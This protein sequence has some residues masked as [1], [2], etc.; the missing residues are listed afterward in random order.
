M[1]LIQRIPGR[2][3]LLLGVTIFGAANAVTRQLTELGAENLID[4]RNPISFCNVLFVGNIWAL[5]IF[6][7]LY[8]QQINQETIKKLSGKDWLSLTSVAILAGALAPALF[9]SALERTMVNNVILV[10][11]IEP[12]LVLALSIFL[13]HERVNRWVI[14]GAI[15]SFI[16]VG[17]TVF[18]PDPNRE[19]MSMASFQIGT[20][21]LMVAV[22]A[23]SAAVATIISKVSLRNI[24][25]GFFNIYRTFLST[26]V[27]FIIVTLLFGI[28]HFMDIFSPL[29]WQW[30]LLYSLVIVVGGQFCWFSGLQKS[31]ASEISLANSFAP[32]AGVLASYLILG[33]VPT[34]PQYIG[35]SVIILGI[36][37]NQIGVSKVPSQP[38]ELPPL[39]RSTEDIDRTVGFKGV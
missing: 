11:R 17:L 5:V 27:F 36:I 7:L 12:P 32:I 16:G 31:S 35:G 20:G 38:S 23:V 14:I 9:F 33:E 18:I 2:A 25:L 21:E 1:N 10:S 39:D 37:F 34:T 22:G 30:M 19:M 3:Y 24:S 15:V 29:V 26:V 28:G 4:G 6:L 8:Y 13:L